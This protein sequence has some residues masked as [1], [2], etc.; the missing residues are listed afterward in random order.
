MAHTPPLRVLRILLAD[1]TRIS[2]LVAKTVLEN[3]G[4]HVT[5]AEDGE[6]AW[7]LLLTEGP[8]DLLLTD[9]QMPKLDGSALIAMVTHAGAEQAI[10]DTLAALAPSDSLLGEP[11]V[12]HI[13]GE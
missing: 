12:M 4:H 5:L 9:I 1:D 7:E 2:Q 8:F 11:M 6:L 10:N 3:V 13:L